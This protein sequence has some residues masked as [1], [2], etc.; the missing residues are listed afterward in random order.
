MISRYYSLIMRWYRSTKEFNRHLDPLSSS[1]NKTI[2]RLLQNENNYRRRLQINV[3]FQLVHFFF[4]S[5]YPIQKIVT[6]SDTNYKAINKSATRLVD[7][8]NWSFETTKRKEMRRERKISSR[9][10]NLKNNT[11]TPFFLPYSYY[12][13]L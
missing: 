11:C 8:K 6:H 12:F 5:I 2:A 4:F 9:I 10:F 13:Y 7:N 1:Y 3:G